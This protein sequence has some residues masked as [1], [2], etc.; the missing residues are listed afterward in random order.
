[1]GG[2]SSV[3]KSLRYLALQFDTSLRP[4]IQSEG[5][6]LFLSTKVFLRGYIEIAASP[7]A[8]PPRLSESDGGQ[9]PRNDTIVA[10]V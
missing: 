8:R 1:M 9:A 7:S 2:D 4:P 5:S 10:L 3:S 6:N